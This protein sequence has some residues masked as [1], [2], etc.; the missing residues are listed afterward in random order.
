MSRTSRFFFVF[1]YGWTNLIG[2]ARSIDSDPSLFFSDDV[3]FAATDISNNEGL[4]SDLFSESGSI[5]DQANLDFSSETT[6]AL[7]NWDSQWLNFDDSDLDVVEASCTGGN[8]GIQTIGKMR[9]E[10]GQIC[11]QQPGRNDPDFSNLRIPTFMQ[12]EE[13]LKDGQTKP[14]A[15]A[16]AASEE[17][18][19]DDCP[20][21]YGRHVCCT[22]PGVQ[23]FP[24]SGIWDFVQNC[25]PCT[26]SN[27][28]P[29]YMSSRINPADP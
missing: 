3:G 19:D 18:D 14:D 1:L 5:F 26:C 8:G 16:G 29:S 10:T 27:A 28:K 2:V 9:R 4:P 17:N 23:S 24:D 11:T 21:L 15:N 12:I 22:G 7:A 25:N 6:P 13:T 20:A